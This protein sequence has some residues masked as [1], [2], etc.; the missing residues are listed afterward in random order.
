[1]ELT[2]R[3]CPAFL[4]DDS[5][6]YHLL[7]TQREILWIWGLWKWKNFLPSAI[8][9]SLW[10]SR[11]WNLEVLANLYWN[12]KDSFYC[13]LFLLPFQISLYHI[14]VG[15][16][17]EDLLW[18]QTLLYGSFLIIFISVFTGWITG[19][20]ALST[21]RNSCSFDSFISFTRK[22]QN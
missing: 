8:P 16:F 20:P 11:I 7:M 6:T 10:L 5:L 1:M 3:S 9:D 13:S 18:F 21:S 14:A 17:L 15:D 12:R 19:S 2:Q 4:C 22:Y